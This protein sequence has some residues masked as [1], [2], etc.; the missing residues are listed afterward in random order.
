MLEALK[1]DAIPDHMKFF[2]VAPDFGQSIHQGFADAD[3]RC[4]GFRCF[5]DQAA[6]A[7]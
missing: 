1:V 3:R 2:R 6:R 7:G 4:C 5:E